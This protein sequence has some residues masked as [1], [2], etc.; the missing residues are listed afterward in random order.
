MQPAPA[1]P[2]ATFATRAVIL[3]GVWWMLTLGDSSAWG[4]GAIVIALAA[5]LSVLLFPPSIHRLR[6]LGLL[7]FMVYFLGHSVVAGVDVARRLLTPSLPIKPGEITL[8][9]RLPE[10]GPRWL[11]ANTLSLMPGA[12]SVHMESNQL[13]VHCLDTSADIE[14]GVRQAEFQVARAFGIFLGPQ[15]GVRL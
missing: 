6:P 8:S 1:S 9:L 13:T 7:Q 5:V 4:F 3:A 11:L 15:E 14:P 12:L 10:G 2:I